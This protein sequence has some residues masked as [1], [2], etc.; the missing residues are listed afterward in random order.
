LGLAGGSIHGYD[1]P[2]FADYLA[3]NR[4][5]RP[6]DHLFVEWFA[7]ERPASAVDKAGRPHLALAFNL[8]EH[9]G[10]S[11]SLRGGTSP[12]YAYC[13]DALDAAVVFEVEAFDAVSC[14]ERDIIS[15]CPGAEGGRALPASTVDF[16]WLKSRSK[17]DSVQGWAVPAPP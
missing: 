1:V 14:G 7:G 6:P 11:S 9:F 17:D 8:L 3:E 16:G 10:R 5:R 13:Y 2:V 12:I 15:P 4:A